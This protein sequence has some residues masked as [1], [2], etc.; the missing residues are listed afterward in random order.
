MLYEIK[1]INYNSVECPRYPPS[2]KSMSRTDMLYGYLGRLRFP[3]TYYSSC[4]SRFQDN[5]SIS[6]QHKN[7]LGTHAAYRLTRRVR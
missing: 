7:R 2:I 1:G 4:C 3:F 5:L 6:A